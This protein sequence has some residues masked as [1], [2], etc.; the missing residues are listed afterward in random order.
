MNTSAHIAH[1]A[2]TLLSEGLDDEDDE[3]GL[4]TDPHQLDAL[5]LV[6]DDEDDAPPPSLRDLELALSPIPSDDGDEDGLALDMGSLLNRPEPVY[7]VDLDAGPL[8]WDTTDGM[9]LSGL[10]A[11]TEIADDA[12]DR[13]LNLEPI[14]LPPLGAD[15][16]RSE[17]LDLSELFAGDS[18]TP[19]V[20]DATLWHE[21]RLVADDTSLL[22]VD[23]SKVRWVAAGRDLVWLHEQGQNKIRCSVEGGKIASLSLLHDTAVYIAGTGVIG[24]RNARASQPE[25]LGRAPGT[26]PHKARIGRQSVGTTERLWL[27]SSGELSLSL[28]LGAHWTAVT[29]LG[30]V[31]DVSGTGCELTALARRDDGLFLW[32]WN[33]PDEEPQSLRLQD[34]V[35]DR[36]RQAVA[37]RVAALDNLVVVWDQDRGAFCSS[38]WGKSFERC[39]AFAV[40][41]ASV[42]GWLDERPTVW[43]ADYDAAIDEGCL[44]QLTPEA[45]AGKRIARLQAL[46]ERNGDADASVPQNRIRGLCWDEGLTRL[47]AVG[48]FGISCLSRPA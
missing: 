7:E 45:P 13:E 20:E 36:L 30:S 26:E 27:V 40:P 31:L 29:G 24:R 44:W 37:P 48:A 2:S 42:V 17:L 8:E 9:L 21:E 19:G 4:G 3:E 25:L 35:G 16:D 23:A 5:E 18:F 22:A 1:S 28:D 32:R 15:D 11:L 10:G 33:T 41:T 14:E 12:L 47:L 43:L 34:A 46:P 39:R 38:D 6:P